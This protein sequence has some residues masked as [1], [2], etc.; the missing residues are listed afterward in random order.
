MILQFTHEN[1]PGT[2]KRLCMVRVELQMERWLGATRFRSGGFP[3]SRRQPKT[4]VPPL[5]RKSL[6]PS[7]LEG[8]LLF[9]EGSEDLLIQRGLLLVQSQKILELLIRYAK[10][11]RHDADAFHLFVGKHRIRAGCREAV[12]HEAVFGVLELV[13]GLDLLY[14]LVLSPLGPERLDVSE[15]GFRRAECGLVA[16]DPF[17]LL[18]VEHAVGGGADEEGGGVDLNR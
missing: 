11:L 2:C 6:L 17:Q 18:G 9:V 13:T 3:R 16:D 5:S 7:S 1:L 10:R 15:D 12:E 14:Q 4:Q 8:V